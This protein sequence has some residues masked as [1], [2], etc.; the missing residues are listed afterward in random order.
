MF[1]NTIKCVN[2]YYNKTGKE[3]KPDHW[4]LGETTANR[5]LM[6]IGSEAWEEIEESL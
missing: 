2:L 5:T 1:L 3:K 4:S 6:L